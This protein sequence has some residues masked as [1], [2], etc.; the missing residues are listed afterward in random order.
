M[1][2]QIVQ[3]KNHNAYPIWNFTLNNFALSDI[4]HIPNGLRDIYAWYKCENCEFD[5][6]VSRTIRNIESISPNNFQGKISNGISVLRSFSSDESRALGIGIVS[7][8]TELCWEYSSREKLISGHLRNNCE[9]K[10][11]FGKSCSIL[12][13]QIYREKCDFIIFS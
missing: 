9:T 3:K 11:F 13:R 8:R 6:P 2:F 1:D 4:F 12:N 5:T 10:I 7:S